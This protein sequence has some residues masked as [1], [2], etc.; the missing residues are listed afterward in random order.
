MRGARLCSTG[1]GRA[2]PAFVRHMR[3]DAPCRMGICARRPGKSALL[4]TLVRLWGW[5]ASAL[6]TLTGSAAAEP[7][8]PRHPTDLHSLIEL[9]DDS[10][11]RGRLTT[12]ALVLRGDYAPAPWVSLRLD[13][14]LLLYVDNPTTRPALGVGV[15]YSRAT[16]RLFA[17]DV[18]LLAGADLSLDSAA[19]KTLGSGKNIFGPFATIAWDFG[20]GVWL[21]LQL[22]QLASIGGDP[23]AP[24]VSATSARPYALLALPEGYW[25]LLDQTFRVD[26]KGARD[27]SYLGV[28]EGGKEVT[29]E[30]SIYVDPGVQIDRPWALTWLLTGG[31]RWTMP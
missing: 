24:S 14:P 1:R 8:Q 27:F 23:K 30:I 11:R 12:N 13:L 16:L 4:L 25:V 19:T 18:S 22:Q 28:F 15:V 31:V 21:R 5:A 2:S 17:S 9:R 26:H 3:C 10:T 20:P 29:K 7:A 6:T